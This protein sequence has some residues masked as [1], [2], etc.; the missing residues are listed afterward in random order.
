MRAQYGARKMRR[1]RRGRGK[2]T[3][4]VLL[5]SGLGL[6]A[7]ASCYQSS[8][9]APDQPP[10]RPTTTSTTTTMVGPTTTTS[11]LV[12]YASQVHPIWNDQGCTASGCHSGGPSPNL[13]G[14]PADSCNGLATQDGANPNLIITGGS[15]ASSE[16]LAKPNPGGISHVGGG[17]PCFAG[18]GSACYDVVLRW[19][20]QGANGPGGST[21]GG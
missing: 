18:A 4:A 12:D 19:L 8:P 5:L 2:G 21:C 11:G 20:Q 16:I 15:A 10:P 9:M 7:L 1:D 13:G 14:S 17:F 3:L 6:V